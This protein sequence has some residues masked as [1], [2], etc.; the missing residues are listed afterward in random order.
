MYDALVK[1]GPANP[2]V[3]RVGLDSGL[4]CHG[5]IQHGHMDQELVAALDACHR[6]V[7]T[8][9]GALGFHLVWDVQA[10]GQRH[11]AGYSPT[12]HFSD[13]A[14]RNQM[15]RTLNQFLVHAGAAPRYLPVEGC[16]WRQDLSD[17]AGI[18]VRI[19]DKEREAML[20]TTVSDFN[21]VL[22]ATGAEALQKPQEYRRRKEHG[23]QIA[24]QNLRAGM[25]STDPVSIAKFRADFGEYVGDISLWG[26]VID[27]YAMYILDFDGVVIDA[28][29]AQQFLESPLSADINLASGLTPAG[30]LAL[31]TRDGPLK[32]D[33]LRELT[34]AAARALAIHRDNLRMNG[35]VGI[36]DET[37]AALGQHQGDWLSLDGL[38]E[39]SAKS[40]A[41]LAKHRGGWLSLNGV[42][43]LN[44]PAAAALAGYPG[45][46]SLNGV[47]SLSEKACALLAKHSGGVLHLNGLTQLTDGCAA[48][49]AKHRH[50]LHL[51]GVCELLPSAAQLLAKHS[52]DLHLNG[53]EQL[54]VGT[55]AA[56]ATHKGK[57]LGLNN[58]IA[59]SD[60]A[61]EALAAH[62][63]KL[64]LNGLEYLSEESAEAFAKHQ[65]RLEM[66]GLKVIS[67][68]AAEALARHRGTYL[69]L[70]GLVAVSPDGAEALSR[71]RGAEL[72]LGRLVALSRQAAKKLIQNSNIYVS[73]QLEFV[74]VD[75]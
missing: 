19:S 46:L 5:K 58:L 39:L 75:G 16:N 41:E 70:N 31:A 24:M 6:A 67:D 25:V 62:P 17:G 59:I 27:S 38:L 22:R 45:G 32:L 50:K 48:A 2:I 47:T 23:I 64:E 9:Q 66:N 35:V 60:E 11:S 42:R 3:L 53:L 33:G 4:Y 65:N 10:S 18:L 21:F 71:Y 49:L 30:A 72:F 63:G 36:T 12:R 7:S 54:S 14:Y 34:T 43:Q 68:Q 28:D 74:A 55:A 26:D 20:I 73:D 8:S 1:K 51:G 13:I 37:A 44:E 56:L 57:W 29:R 69:H 40:A 15:I 61:A 52:E